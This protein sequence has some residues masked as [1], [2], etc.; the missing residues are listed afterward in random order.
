MNERIPTHQLTSDKASIPALKIFRFKNSSQLETEASSLPITPLPTDSPHR[1]TYYEILFIEQGQ[2][3]HEIDFQTYPIQGAGL[4]FL[5]PGQV[6][7]LTL[8]GPCQG[9]IIAFSEDYFSFY[10]PDSQGLASFPFFRSKQRQAVVAL[11][12]NDRKYFHNVLENMVNDH[13]T[14]EADRILTG[15]YL[16]IL[17]QK[18]AFLAKKNETEQVPSF[19]LPELVTQFK[20][21]A[22]KQYQSLHDVQ[23]YA[24]TL[25]VSAD[26]LSK[27]VK[28]HLGVS[29]GEYIQAKLLMEAKRLL[30]F[31]PL[32]SKEIAYTLQIED[33]SYFGRLFKRKTGLTPKEYRQSVRKSAI[34]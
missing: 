28:K 8:H 15:K 18:G 12:E 4:H 13:L 25:N 10:N 20:E 16:G 26:Y 7:L 9:Y 34:I 11:V 30:V 17:L 31:T 21:L 32:S 22:D 2:G 5:M 24:S 33:P 1:H 14:A 29:A 23:S 19:S 3:F 6:H 27:S